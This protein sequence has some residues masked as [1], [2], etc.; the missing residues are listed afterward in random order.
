M[1]SN[2]TAWPV[3]WP[4]NTCYIFNGKLERNQACLEFMPAVTPDM[5]SFLSLTSL[6]V[7]KQ[8]YCLDPP[9]DDSCSFGHCPNPDVAGYAIVSF[10]YRKHRLNIIVGEGQLIIR[11][12]IIVARLVWISTFVFIL[13]DKRLVDFTQASLAAVP[14]LTPG[15]ALGTI[16]STVIPWIVAIVLQRKVM[17]K[18]RTLVATVWQNLVSGWADMLF[19]R[20]TT[21]T[22]IPT[23]YWISVV[24]LES[25][26]EF[27]LSFNQV[28]ATFVALPPLFTILITGFKNLAWVCYIR[29]YI[30]RAPTNVRGQGGSELSL[31]DL[32]Y[33]STYQEGKHRF[34]TYVQIPDAYSM[35][36]LEHYTTR[37]GRVD[38]PS[39]SKLKYETHGYTAKPADTGQG[40]L[41]LGQNNQCAFPC[42]ISES[43]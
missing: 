41:S 15:V 33:L 19:V 24:E 22:S 8:A 31:E 2:V 38:A 4:P 34:L 14:S 20:F 35:K 40:Y 9:E 5:I 42:V 28:L 39:N 6:D 12:L 11:L 37:L 23:T 7:F 26:E 16:E 13:A 32:G 17:E 18:G 1:S 29:S 36:G 27:S 30:Y 43:C 21:L 25:R 3:S 10:W